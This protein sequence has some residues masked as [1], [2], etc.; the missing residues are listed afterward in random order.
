MSAPSEPQTWLAILAH[1]AILFAF[2]PVLV[3]V[4]ARTKAWFA[5]R[6]GPPLLQAWYDIVKQWRKGLV[7]SRTTTPLFA[8]GPLAGMAAVIIAGLCVPAA[9]VPAPIAFAGDALLVAYLLGL[10]RFLTIL[11]ALDTGSSFEGMGASR[12][13]LY[14]TLAE[15]ALFLGLAALLAL[16]QPGAGFSLTPLLAAAPGLWGS[17]GGALA[18]IAAAW[19][20][21]VL[22]ENCRVPFDDPNTHLELTMIHEVMV[23]DHSGP[24]YG[25]VLYGAAMKLTLFAMLFAGLVVP[26]SGH[27]LGD[28]ALSLAGIVLVGVLIGIIE[29]SLA[30]LRLPRVPV[31]LAAAGLLAAFA[32]ILPGV[33]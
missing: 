29:S 5:G 22:V 31:V 2:P 10:A 14:G 21:V 23:L 19:L 12:E 32:L 27:P 13:A 1:L 3:G 4:I 16:A 28:A 26:R 30:R 24:P 25:F 17:V 33:R 18:L 9:A 20:I 11:A 6:R 15:P 8:L 7:L